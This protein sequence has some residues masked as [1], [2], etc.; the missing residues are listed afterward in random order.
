MISSGAISNVS[1]HAEVR[2]VIANIIA[3]FAL[4]TFTGIFLIL[5]WF[6][7]Q[8]SKLHR[9]FACICVF[10]TPILASALA[11]NVAFL[12]MRVANATKIGNFYVDEITIN[13]HGCEVLSENGVDLCNTKIGDSYKIHDVYVMSRIGSE[14][15]LKIN[16]N[17]KVKH[18]CSSTQAAKKDDKNSSIE[19]AEKEKEMKGNIVD[20]AK[21]NMRDV[22]IPSAD[23]QGLKISAIPSVFSL[24]A[25]NEFMKDKRSICATPPT[26]DKKIF[27][28]KE[29]DL[30]E[31]GQ[32]AIKPEGI[33][34][35]EKLAQE[36]DTNK[37]HI[38][39]ID[40]AG[41][42]DQIGTEQYN[43][44]LSQ[45][46][47]LSV[48]NFLR[49]KVSKEIDTHVFS[50]RGYGSTRPKKSDIDCPTTLNFAMRKVC[51]ADNRRVDVE[52]VY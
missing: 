22:L 11:G 16:V 26:S 47:A 37:T 24:A 21:R 29:S 6:N 44:N 8:P 27:S 41:F 30:F 1:E 48:E 38:A 28:F 10:L 19:D 34:K 32:Y 18:P 2:N 23:I 12:W 7:P 4:V 25:I 43:L 52:L 46:R 9:T 13:K 20:E 51:L 5:A 3:P 49:D 35:F 14:T 45:L 40:I 39:K 33:K 17:E 50:S 15:F 36:I 42:A 31:F